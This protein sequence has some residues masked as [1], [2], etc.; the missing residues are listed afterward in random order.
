MS[1]PPTPASTVPLE[2][3]IPNLLRLTH[4][5][6]LQAIEP[7]LEAHGIP[8]PAWKY[9]RALWAQDGVVAAEVAAALRTRREEA[10]SAYELLE[11]RGLVQRQQPDAGS[12][13]RLLL[14]AEGRGLQHTL[15][16]IT[17][18]IVEDGLRELS[19]AE[20]SELRRLLTTVLGTLRGRS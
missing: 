10:E 2:Q 19:A 14:T 13:P 17:T 9:L 20:R 18:R 7:H 11:S 8:L 6:F 4:L 12:P 16:P 1:P 15:G 5:E 3:S